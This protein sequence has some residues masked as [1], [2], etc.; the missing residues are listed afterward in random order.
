MRSLDVGL[1]SH[2]AFLSHTLCYAAMLDREIAPLGILRLVFD[3]RTLAH[4]FILQGR[5][6]AW[7]LCTHHWLIFV[8]RCTVLGIACKRSLYID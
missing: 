3:T 6:A 2:D 5:R 7:R 1:A 8:C 4:W